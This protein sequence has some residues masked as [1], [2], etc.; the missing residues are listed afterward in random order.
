MVSLLED[1][2][3]D[4]KVQNLPH[5]ISSEEFLYFAQFSKNKHGVDMQEQ[6]N[7]SFAD[8]IIDNVD[9]DHVFQSSNFQSLVEQALEGTLYNLMQEVD[10]KE[11]SLHDYPMLFQP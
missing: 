7:V 3:Q 2:F 8:A 4:E 9:A 10:S 5:Q 11:F 6:E 1:A